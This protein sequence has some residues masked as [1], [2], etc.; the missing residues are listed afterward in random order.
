M[1]ENNS[2]LPVKVDKSIEKTDLYNQVVDF[3]KS[4]ISDNFHW[5]ELKS[6][7]CSECKL[8]YYNFNN[9]EILDLDILGTFQQCNSQITLFHCLN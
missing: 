3:L 8:A 6:K 7:F 2:N 1:K 9:Y 5:F 4:K